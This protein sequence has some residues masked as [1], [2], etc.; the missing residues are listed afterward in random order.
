MSI[1]KIL[2]N[3]SGILS[4]YLSKR[5]QKRIE[6]KEIQDLGTGVHG[7]AYKAISLE[8]ES[9]VI[10]EFMDSG[11]NLEFSE[12]RLKEALLHKRTANNTPGHVKI[13]DIIQFSNNQLTP[14]NDSDPIIVMEEAL[15][16][17]YF[18]DLSKI[19]KNQ[20]L[21]D[22]DKERIKVI[23]QKV[24]EIHNHK[25][26]KEHY[27][28]YLRDWMGM[29]ILDLTNELSNFTQKE[30]QEVNHFF[31]DWQQLLSKNSDRCKRIHGELFPGT[32]KLG[33]DN[34]FVTYDMRRIGAGEP[35][36]DVG[37][38]AYNFLFQSILDHKKII[39]CFV[40]ATKLF[41]EEYIKHS[42][43]PEITKFLPVFMAFRC[44]ICIHPTI[45]PIPIETKKQL[46]KMLFTLLKQKDLD[47][48]KI[49]KLYN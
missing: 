28:R 37:S 12:D 21:S 33:P 11:R 42:K 19:S 39:P 18:S 36:D 47:L 9:F 32:I 40:E 14:I 1:K 8:N 24:A 44:L 13:H 38:V 45:V 26:P 22:N 41:L 30:V 6:I 46:K 16:E 23:A 7:H 2:N 48:D 27:L 3:K 29:G 5:F 15:Y 25:E 43:D 49:I 31:I 34:E 10:K 17:E 35:A 4:N 20:K